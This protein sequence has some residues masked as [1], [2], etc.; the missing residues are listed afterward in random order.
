MISKSFTSAPY[1]ARALAK[2]GAVARVIDCCPSDKV[3][4][5]GHPVGP[6]QHNIAFKTPI[7]NTVSGTET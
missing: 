7:V 6:T 5:I 1:P 2:A 4:Y 3:N